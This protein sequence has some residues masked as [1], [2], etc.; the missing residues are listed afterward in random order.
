MAD[1]QPTDARQ[2]QP[3]ATA[4]GGGEVGDGYR[5]ELPD[6]GVYLRWPQEG[7][8]WI[9]EDDLEQALQMVPSDRVFC[10]YRWD[11][12]FYWL[13]YGP[14]KIRV[15]P[16]LWLTVG[17]VDLSIGQQVEVLFRFGDN[18][19]GIFEL[20]EIRYLPRHGQVIYQ[21]RRG[22]LLLA[23]EFSRSDLRPLHQP[24]VLRSGFYQHLP[25]KSVDPE[26]ANRLDV[27]DLLQREPRQ[28]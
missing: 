14:A 22:D 27:G 24:H 12:S 20:A 28:P 6:W 3:P 23:H 17:N 18:D 1:K 11:G 21:V 2:D 8:Q 16:T 13:K 15:R 4:R 5:P 9:H 26:D 10:R 19:P 7:Q 25:Q